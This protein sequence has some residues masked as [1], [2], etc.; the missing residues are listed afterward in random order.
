MAE[1]EERQEHTWERENILRR[2]D[3]ENYKVFFDVEMNKKKLGR[4]VFVL[5]RRI[6]PKM[7][8]NMRGKCTGEYGYD[9]MMM[10][11]NWLNC[12]FYRIGLD[13]I[14]QFGCGS[15]VYGEEFDDDPGGLKLKHDRPYLL[16]AA[17]AGPNTNTGDFSIMLSPSPWLDGGYTIFGEVI[18]GQ[19]IV[20]TIN[21]AANTS[22][23]D[24]FGF[25]L[26]PESEKDKA[27]VVNTGQ[28]LKNNTIISPPKN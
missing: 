3:P 26:Y 25:E 19:N 6:S 22:M 27:Y 20:H 2:D 5:Y 28:I 11:L 14:D 8:E 10:P 4:I 15:S 7:S 13:W 16:S 12:Y 23:A 9:K 1:A 21:Q 18:E 17:N 24:G